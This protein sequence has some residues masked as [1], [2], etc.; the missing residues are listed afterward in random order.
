MSKRRI[1]ITGATGN[2]GR[3]GLEEL[4]E[5]DDR[6]EVSALVLPTDKDRQIIAPY[7]K[8]GVTVVWGDLTCYEDVL[9][10]VS[11]ADIVLHVG[12]L[13]Y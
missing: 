10:G 8:R 13:V 7:Q 12:A 11:G 6:Y 3:H 4:L 2:M 1:F 9:R 5:R